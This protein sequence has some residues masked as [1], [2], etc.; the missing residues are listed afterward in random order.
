MTTKWKKPITIDWDNETIS[1]TYKFWGTIDGNK[2]EETE[3]YKF[4]LSS[5]E[6]TFK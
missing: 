1:T 3:K 6:Y 4:K 5:H 2:Y